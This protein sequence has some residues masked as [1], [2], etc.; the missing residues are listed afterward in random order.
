MDTFAPFAPTVV[1]DHRPST[2]GAS[3][4]GLRSLVAGAVRRPRVETD[5]RALTGVEAVVVFDF[6]SLDSETRRRAA[7]RAISPVNAALA[8]V[9]D[10]VPGIPVL[11]QHESALALSGRGRL[12]IDLEQSVREAA[13]LADGDHVD[14]GRVVDALAGLVDR[15]GWTSVGVVAHPAHLARCVATCQR[16]GLRVVAAPTDHLAALWDP[17]SSQWWTR[18]PASWTLRELAVVAHQMLTGRVLLRW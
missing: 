15:A 10:L 14:T 17:A 6:G 9:T 1:T 3:P 4:V 2:A 11:A 18:R 7:G 8:S 16:L 13:G 5:A 12:V